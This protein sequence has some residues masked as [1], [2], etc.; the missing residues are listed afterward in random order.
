MIARKY[1][2][3][4]Q[5]GPGRPPVMTEIRQLVVRMATENRDWG[6]TRI[7]GV[8]AN[9]DHHVA[10]GTIANILKQQ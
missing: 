7:Q 5:R 10:R 6:Y 8:L 3:H 2:G 4:R 9:L 1:D